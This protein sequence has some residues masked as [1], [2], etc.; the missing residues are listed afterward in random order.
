MRIESAFIGHFLC[1]VETVKRFVNVHLH[2]NVSN[3][4]KLSKTLTLLH[5]EIISADA[6]GFFHPFNKL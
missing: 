5:P 2:C 4:K 1:G 3:L 6:H